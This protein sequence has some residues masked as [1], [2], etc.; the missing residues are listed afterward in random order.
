MI[1]SLIGMP[2]S[3]KS[4]LAQQLLKYNHKLHVISLDQYIED[5]YNL[6]IVEIFTQY[7]EYYFRQLESKLLQQLI[8]RYYITNGQ[9][10]VLDLGGGAFINAQNRKLCLQYTYVIWLNTDFDIIEDNL[11]YQLTQRPLLMH[12]ENLFTHLQQLYQ[13]RAPCYAQAQQSYIINSDNFDNMLQLIIQDI[14]DFLRNYG[15]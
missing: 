10:L 9:H 15:C 2:G 6:S 7:G 8:L 14:N 11:K 12:I 1:I 4:F 3:G 5:R 13:Q